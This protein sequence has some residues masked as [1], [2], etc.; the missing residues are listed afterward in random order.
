MWDFSRIQLAPVTSDSFPLFSVQTRG[1]GT[2]FES[3]STI[4][5][6]RLRNHHLAIF[7][8]KISS[9]QP[10]LPVSGQLVNPGGLTVSLQLD[11]RIC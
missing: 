2:E 8:A 9:L 1:E 6:E 10:Q 4:Q 11:A 5:I 3:R 7:A